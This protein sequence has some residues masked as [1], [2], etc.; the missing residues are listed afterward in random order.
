MVI[1]N[2]EQVS[3]GKPRRDYDASTASRFGLLVTRVLNRGAFKLLRVS[4]N[5]LFREIDVAERR[6]PRDKAWETGGWMEEEA[7]QTQTKRT[8]ASFL[9]HD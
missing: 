5:V 4:I 6:S 8:L 2:C 7:R 3:V 1:T 9:V